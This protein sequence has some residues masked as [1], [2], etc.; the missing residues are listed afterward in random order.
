MFRYFFRFF[1]LRNNLDSYRDKMHYPKPCVQHHEKL[2]RTGPT[3]HGLQLVLDPVDLPESGQED[4]DGPGLLQVLTT[5]QIPQ[6]LGDDL[7]AFL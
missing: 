5:L 6:P 1:S 2:Y 3:H 4:Q 7:Y